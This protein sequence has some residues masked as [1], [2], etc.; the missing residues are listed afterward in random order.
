MDEQTRERWINAILSSG[1]H[2]IRA[3]TAFAGAFK[4]KPV[5]GVGGAGGAG[6]PVTGG[7]GKKGE[8]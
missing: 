7:G 2:L 3:L 4:E 1:P 5:R 6:K 8:L